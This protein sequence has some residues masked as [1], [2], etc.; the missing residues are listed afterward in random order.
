MSLKEEFRKA[1]ALENELQESTLRRDSPEYQK[2]ARET[3][4]TFSRC[5]ALVDQL[6]LF[7][8]NE[9]TDDIATN[10]IVYLEV[11][12]HVAKAYERIQGQ[13]SAQDRLTALESAVTHYLAFLETLDNYK[14]LP[15]TFSSRLRE[16]LSKRATS[17]TYL[18]LLQ[19]GDAT[20]RRTDKIERFKLEK[21]LKE[22]L[23]TVT[24]GE[25]DEETTRGSL[26]AM[27]GLNSLSA[28]SSLESMNMEL[29]LLRNHA[30]NP[31]Q[32]TPQ[33]PE[34]QSRGDGPQSKKDYIPGKVDNPQTS[35]LLDRKTGKVLRP[36]TLVKSRDQ[37]QNNVRGYGQY[38]PTMTVEEYL[39]EEIRQGRVLQGG[40]EKHESSDEDDEAKADEATYKARR[41]D[42]FVEANP[43][44]SG[45]TINRG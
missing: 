1:L 10:D 25:R 24:E 38:M 36:F 37:I 39:D 26:F 5:G 9:T 28:L 29:Q 18:D 44:G 3:L 33:D 14:L 41:W 2:K 8:D 13:G 22:K 30:N 12:F 7:S 43:R 6:A 11:P 31:E 4:T 17:P 40:E 35:G 23:Q 42:E 34:S 32:N 19:S 20:A 16:A 27:Q 15:K 21:S 45:N